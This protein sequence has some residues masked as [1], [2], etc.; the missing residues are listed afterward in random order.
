MG[1]SIRVIPILGLIEG[2]LVKT[3][4]F[5]K[6][7]YIG[8]PINAIKIF[9]DKE[10]D[11]ITILDIRAS[12]KGTG[13]NYKLIEEMAGECFMPLSYGGGVDTFEKAKT[14]FE[15]GVE[16]LVINSALATQPDLAAEIA[17][18]YGAQSVVGCM[19]VKKSLFGKYQCFTKSGQQKVSADPEAYA[20]KLET[21]GVGELLLNNISL[22]GTF[23]GY[24]IELIKRISRSVGI[25]LI[26]AG[27]ASD[28]DNLIQAAS[29]GEASA[30]SASSMF[31]YK[32]QNTA[33]ILINYPTE[34]V[35]IA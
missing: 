20:K 28:F 5:K 7:N 3:V 30:V 10:V 23:K 19:D 12:Q 33:S 2:R 6:P 35:K 15:L 18:T 1:R 13:L 24:D 11:E 16:K 27:G 32:N 34:Q 31:V 25:P 21:A 9:N 17:A 29:V 14:L 4:N 26:A 22:D 8:D